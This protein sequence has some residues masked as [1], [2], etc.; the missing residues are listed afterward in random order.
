MLTLFDRGGWV[1]WPLLAAAIIGIAYILERFFTLFRARV[2]PGIFVEQVKSAYEGGGVQSAIAFCNQNPN[3]VARIFVPALEKFGKYKGSSDLKTILEEAITSAGSVELAFLDRGMLV[4]A[5][6]ASV[7]PLIGFLG[8]V[9]GMIQ[10]FDAIAVAGTIEPTLVATGIS[11]ALITTAT[12]LTIAV[13]T[14]AAHVFF[15]SRIN[16]YT[17]A[18]EQASNSLIEY[19]LEEVEKGAGG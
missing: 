18:M 1:M 12:G 11:V 10:A 17:R 5:A 2:N 16:T 7:A 19:L 8:T 3:P 6:V 9:I 14:A 13:P 15:T 4:L